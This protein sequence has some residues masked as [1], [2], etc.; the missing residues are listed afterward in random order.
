M[1]LFRLEGRSIVIVGGLGR[2]GRG[3]LECLLEAGAQVL[4]LDVVPDGEAVLESCLGSGCLEQVAYERFSVTEFPGLSERIAE[5]WARFPFDGWVNCAY[6]AARE[7]E[8]GI[9]ETSWLE[10]LQRHVGASCLCSEAAAEVMAPG[11][12][13]VS[14]GSVYGVLG[15]DF[16]IY[17]GT[18]KFTPSTYS[19]AK[20]AILSHARWLASRHGSKGIRVNVV[21]PGG[22]QN[23][24][25][26][27]F[28]SQYNAKTLLGRMATAREVGAAVVFFLSDA[29]GCTTGEFL[30]IDGGMS[31]T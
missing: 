27:P 9:P 3:V 16:R 13:I 24:Q 23:N 11:G 6:P 30:M 25:T 8:N 19:A 31:C 14:L 15:P 7:N 20:G 17:N 28:L 22:V 21:C 29:A 2:V 26:E 4:V 5:L 18:D 10:A 1:R 12:A